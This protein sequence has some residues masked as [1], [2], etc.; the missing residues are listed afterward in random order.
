MPRYY[1]TLFYVEP[2][3]AARC[4]VP[5]REYRGGFDVEAPDPV[6]AMKRARELFREVERR[7]SVGWARE[8]VRCECEAIAARAGWIPFSPTSA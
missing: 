5:P 3:Y 4:G 2:T 1:V 6:S 8:I 7:S